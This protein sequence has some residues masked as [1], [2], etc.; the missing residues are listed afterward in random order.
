MTLKTGKAPF[1]DRALTPGLQLGLTARSS[2]HLLDKRLLLHR[3]ECDILENSYTNE[4][5]NAFV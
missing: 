5:A 1:A 3:S 4:Y 2:S